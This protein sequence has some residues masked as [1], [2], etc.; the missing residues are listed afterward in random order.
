MWSEPPIVDRALRLLTIGAVVPVTFA[1]LVNIMLLA[2]GL[3]D[4]PIA[5][6]YMILIVLFTC[7]FHWVFRNKPNFWQYS[8]AVICA[9]IGVFVLAPM[10]ASPDYERLGSARPVFPAVVVAVMVGL[11]L[12]NFLLTRHAA[13]MVLT[14]LSD[15]VVNSSLVIV[16]KSRTD[17][18]T[19]HVTPEFIKLLYYTP[20]RHTLTIFDAEVAYALADVSAVTVRRQGV[21]LDHYPVPGLERRDTRVTKGDFVEIDLS[22]ETFVFPAKDCQRFARFVE[23]RCRALVGDG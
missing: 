10:F 8:S 4:A 20:P 22:G 6:G 1:L 17:R 18:D 15:D 5:V 14:N 11:V 13:R 3:S 21:R 7:F 19:V 16:F 2:R 9:C 23:D 12:V